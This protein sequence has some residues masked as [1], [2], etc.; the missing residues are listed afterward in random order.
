MNSDQKKSQD[1]TDDIPLVPSVLS[2]K[3]SIECENSAIEDINT[4][5]EQT[6]SIAELLDAKEEEEENKK[7]K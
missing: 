3:A 6:K 1:Q 7:T 2:V 4:A 5:N